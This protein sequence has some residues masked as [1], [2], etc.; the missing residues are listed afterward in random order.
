M[1]R[2]GFGE[3]ELTRNITKLTF[4]KIIIRMHILSVKAL[5]FNDGPNADNITASSQ[6]GLS[7][8]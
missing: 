2:V 5:F 4:N 6:C 8:F 7:D 1:F 3:R